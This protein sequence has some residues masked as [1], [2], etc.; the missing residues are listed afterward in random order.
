MRIVIGGDHAS[1]ALKAEVVKHLEAKGYAVDDLG[2]FSDESVDY[3]DYAHELCSKI[4]TQE[5]DLGILICG[6]GQGVAMSANKHASIRA[7]LCWN[8]EIVKLSREHNDANVLCFGA[9][10][11]SQE[12][13]LEMVDVFL[14]TNFEG[15]RHQKR[16]NKISC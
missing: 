14:S 2:P 15:G 16:V 6:S 1:P 9:R 11:V 4:E 12:L 13:A 8:T 10:F 7:A 5:S 3:P